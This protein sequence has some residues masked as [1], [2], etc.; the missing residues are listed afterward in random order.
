MLFLHNRDII[1][2]VTDKGHVM[3]QP[4]HSIQARLGGFSAAWPGKGV[5]LG[6]DMGFICTITISSHTNQLIIVGSF[7]LSFPS[8]DCSIS[9]PDIPP[10]TFPST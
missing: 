6:Q 8:R 7:K 5:A 4:G 10:G 1:D 2:S 3:N 9:P